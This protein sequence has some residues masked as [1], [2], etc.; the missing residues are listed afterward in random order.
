MDRLLL[1]EALMARGTDSS[2]GL[3]ATLAAALLDSPR[4]VARRE[5]TVIS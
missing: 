3:V 2:F 1:V 5:A 4:T